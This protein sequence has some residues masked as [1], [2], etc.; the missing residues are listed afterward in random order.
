[1]GM[2]KKVLIFDTSVLCV[3]LEVPYKETFGSGEMVVDK[4][5]I[6]GIIEKERKAKST[7]VLP[8]ASIIETGNHIAQSAGDR[9]KLAHNFAELLHHTADEVSPWAAFTD[10]SEL[11]KP[12]KLKRL[13][14]EWAEKATEKLSMGDVSIIHVAEYYAESG[15]EVEIFTGDEGLKAYQPVAKPILQP[16]RRK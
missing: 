9:C 16:R 4:T 12:E 10:Q 5:Q 1:M 14:T 2:S 7:F 11:W 13:A 15:F 3:W 6:D 8:I